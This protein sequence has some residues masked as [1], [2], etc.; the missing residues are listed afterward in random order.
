MQWHWPAK[1][2][3]NQHTPRWSTFWTVHS[4]SLTTRPFV[5]PFP[6][7]SGLVTKSTPGCNHGCSREWGVGQLLPGRLSYKSGTVFSSGCFGRAATVKETCLAPRSTCTPV[8]D[9]RLCLAAHHDLASGKLPR[10][11]VAGD[12]DIPRQPPSPKKQGQVQQIAR[13]CV[14]FHNYVKPHICPASQRTRIQRA[15][16]LPLPR[17]TRRQVLF[18]ASVRSARSA[19]KNVLDTRL[20]AFAFSRNKQAPV[21]NFFSAVASDGCRLQGVFASSRTKL[22]DTERRDA[23]IQQS[24]PPWQDVSPRSQ[25]RIR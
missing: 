22:H 9:V 15:H 1:T 3:Q 25:P 18:S 7:S 19:V 23:Q 11:A 5:F 12:T 13:C 6:T 4:L 24:A 21:S 16:Q 17:R 2:E 10:V 14:Y 8:T 20:A